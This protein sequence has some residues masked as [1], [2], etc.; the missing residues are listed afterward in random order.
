ML[1]VVS[2]GSPTA[3]EEQGAHGSL[4]VRQQCTHALGRLY[5]PACRSITRAASTRTARDGAAR[6]SGW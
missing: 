4:A 5:R 6:L 2:G 1:F 3:S